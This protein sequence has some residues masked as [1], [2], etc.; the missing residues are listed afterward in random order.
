LPTAPAPSS[1]NL[2][3]KNKRGPLSALEKSWA[4]ADR[5]LSL[6]EPELQ[7]ISFGLGY[8][9]AESVEESETIEEDQEA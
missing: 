4:L 8:A 1:S 5:K 6:D 2:N 7:A 3:K 9:E